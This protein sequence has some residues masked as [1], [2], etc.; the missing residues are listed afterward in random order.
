M[1]F[2]QFEH[3]CELTVFLNEH[4]YCD[5]R[6]N[7][8]QDGFK[9][10]FNVNVTREPVALWFCLWHRIF[11]IYKKRK[12][13]MQ[14]DIIGKKHVQYNYPVQYKRNESILE[15]LL[16]DSVRISTLI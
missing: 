14:C 1:Y 16:V 5:G 2:V 12:N 9:E 4:Y 11:F 3:H 6:W 13:E 10:R 7:C 8:H 15:E